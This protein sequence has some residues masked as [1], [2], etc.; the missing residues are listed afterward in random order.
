MNNKYN[1]MHVIGEINSSMCFWI[2][3]FHQFI[4][5]QNVIRH[6]VVFFSKGIFLIS[7]AIRKYHQTLLSKSVEQLVNWRSYS[8]FINYITHFKHGQEKQRTI[9]LFGNCNWST[10]ESRRNSHMLNYFIPHYYITKQY[11]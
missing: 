7:R 6:L 10:C 3:S 2:V 8:S 5:T 11:L 1:T 4:C 9:L